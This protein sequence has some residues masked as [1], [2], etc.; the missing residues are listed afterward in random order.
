MG[1]CTVSHCTFRQHQRKRKVHRCCK[2]RHH[3]GYI[4][5]QSTCEYHIYH[6]YIWWRNNLYGNRF[7][8]SRRS[9]SGPDTGSDHR[10]VF[11]LLCFG[12]SAK[13]LC[14]YRSLFRTEQRDRLSHGQWSE[15]R[16]RTDIL[17]GKRGKYLSTDRVQCLWSCAQ[18]TKCFVQRVFRIEKWHQC[19]YPAVDFNQSLR[20]RVCFAQCRW[21]NAGSG[22]SRFRGFF[23]GQNENLYTGRCFHDLGFGSGEIWHLG[24]FRQS[25]TWF[26]QR[27]HFQKRS[28]VYHCRKWHDV[29][30]AKHE[31]YHL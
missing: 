4:H 15:R 13:W 23:Y 7:N 16:Y 27:L 19:I 3:R 10:G 12:Q 29:L 25:N 17:Y 8:G 26:P 30:S 18:C 11:R 21:S 9:R 1:Y 6:F 14:A 20:Q 24:R 31:Q 22:R 5:R 28:K 2:W